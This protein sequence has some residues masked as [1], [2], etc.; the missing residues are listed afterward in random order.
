[1]RLVLITGT[2]SGIGQAA[3][4][5]FAAR[6]DRVVGVARREPEEQEGLAGVVADVSDSESMQAMADK[7]LTEHGVPDVIVANAGIG[8]DALFTEAR[9]E[10]WQ[11]LLEVNVLG[12]V[13]TIRPFLPGMLERGSGRILIVS[14][15][16]GKRGTPYYSAY[17]ASKFAL[18]GMA[19]ALRAEL[20]GSGVSVGMI[21]P[22]STVTGFQDQIVRRGPGQ[23]RRRVR[24]HS[25][26]SVA[27]AIVDMA[28]NQRREI[29]LSAEARLLVLMDS[30]VP[31]L[32]DRFLA[33]MLKS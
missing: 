30:L 24:R 6:G 8:L 9:D 12:V 19:D 28:G 27:R 20:H 14:S 23:E 33:R 21:C 7:V 29:V 10:D 17:S 18:H 31:G 13:R 32:V 25:A 26:E 11:R 4:R 1:M 3:A 16:V 2:S 5:Q 15:I 22:S